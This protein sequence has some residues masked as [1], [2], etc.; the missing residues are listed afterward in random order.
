[1]QEEGR[2]SSWGTQIVLCMNDSL[3]AWLAGL[4]MGEWMGWP[5]GGGGGR[6]RCADR[7][8]GEGSIVSRAT[9]FLRKGSVW[10]F[11]MQQF[12]LTPRLSWGADSANVLVVCVLH[13]RMYTLQPLSARTISCT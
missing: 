8:M 1:M 3:I 2:V 10:Y 9:P 4:S 13:D 5:G 6:G 7:I 12:V 11:T